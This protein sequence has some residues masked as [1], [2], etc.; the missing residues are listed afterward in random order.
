MANGDSDGTR[1]KKQMAAN[2][3]NLL[4]AQLVSYVGDTNGRL[5]LI[6]QRNSAQDDYNRLQT[7]T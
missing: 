2:R 7:S 5:D 3:I 4:N 6:A 1:L